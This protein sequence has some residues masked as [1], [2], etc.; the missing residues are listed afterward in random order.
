MLRSWY[1]ELQNR[2]MLLAKS[3]GFCFLLGVLLIFLPL[4]DPRELQGAYVWTKP[5]K[6]FFSVGIYF[7]TIGWLMEYLQN[8]NFVK[9]ISWGIWILMLIEL[10][11]ITYQASLGK[12]SHFN[13]SSLFDGILFQIMGVA[14]VLNSVLVI[15]V[16]LRFRKI[17]DLPP[18]YLMGIRLGLLIFLVA[19]FEGFVMSVNL[20]HTIGAV[21]GQEGFPFLGW[22]KAYGDLRIFH[23]LGLHALQVLPIVAWL[24]LRNDPKK[25]LTFGLVYFLLSFGTFWMALQGKGIAE[26]F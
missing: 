13:I 7:W 6:F 22:A 25:V 15:L 24:F 12:L 21:D 3:G 10:V 5:A 18:G 14:I 4:V 1:T 20:K 9:R 26:W 23:F 8:R 19:G 17:N 2:N 16:F 11:I